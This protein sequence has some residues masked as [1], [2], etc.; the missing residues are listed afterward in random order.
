MSLMV[1]VEGDTDLP[2]I[3]KLAA[4]A[5]LDISAE[6]DAAGK[7]QID[8]C[9]ASYNQA[10]RGAP[11][12]VLRDL[13]NDAV[14]APAFVASCGLHPA[15]WMCFRVAVREMEAWLLADAEAM[16]EFLGISI[17]RIPENPDAE[18]D[19]TA[20]IVR[21]A[22][23]SKRKDLRKKLVPAEGASAQVGPL[24]EATII[25]F[26][27]KHWDATRAATRSDSLR[28]TRAALRALGARW[29]ARVGAK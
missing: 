6:I 25:E 20:T 4:D 9:L 7:D 8:L 3:R 19:P 15:E 28:R 21:L 17:H 23:R 24:Y 22:R 5:G 26:A 16:S 12:L 2:V 14:C 27:E 13:D 29:R 10:A 11:W 18:P 1:V